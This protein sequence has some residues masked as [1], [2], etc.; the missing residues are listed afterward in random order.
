MKIKGF[1]ILP[2]LCLPLVTGPQLVFV[3]TFSGQPVHISF[4]LG[5]HLR[6]L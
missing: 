1:R 5:R 3:T 4:V 2:F 6:R